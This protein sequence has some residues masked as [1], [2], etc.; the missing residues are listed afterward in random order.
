LF[1]ILFYFTSSSTDIGSERNRIVNR[2]EFF[3]AAILALV[4]PPPFC[5]DTKSLFSWW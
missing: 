5:A 3:C 1:I 2:G 4:F